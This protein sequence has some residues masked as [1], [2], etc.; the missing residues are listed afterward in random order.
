MKRRK[1]IKII[2]ISVVITA[3]AAASAVTIHAN[4]NPYVYVSD[5]GEI[6]TRDDSPVE[7]ESLSPDDFTIDPEEIKADKI[8]EE[9]NK[10]MEKLY[11]ENAEKAAPIFKKHGINEDI[12]KS[13]SEEVKIVS[14]ATQKLADSEFNDEEKPIVEMY[15]EHRYGF[16]N[17]YDETDHT[18]E[19]LRRK[20]ETL[21][22]ND[23]LFSLLMGNDV[24]Y[25]KYYADADK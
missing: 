13:W 7:E 10:K 19:Q 16:L 4:L 21:I 22:D 5:D 20:I 6:L 15:L 14:A 18:E 23:R 1:I 8:K 2:V 3:V 9:K 11:E 17:E 25:D 24:V 12:N